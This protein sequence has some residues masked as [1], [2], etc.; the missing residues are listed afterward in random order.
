M[1]EALISKLQHFVQLLPHDKDVLNS[2][3]RERVRKFSPNEPIILEGD[4][5]TVINLVLSGWACRY[6]HLEDGRRQIV[7]FFLPGDLCD[8]NV[9]ILRQMDHSIASIGH[10]SVAEITPKAFDA[11]FENHYRITQGL[12]W[13]SLVAMAIQRE[14]TLNLGQRNAVERI[15]HLLCELFIRLRVAGVARDK[16][17][18]FPIRQIDLAD[19]TGMSPVHV[20]RVLH[21]LRDLQVISL[22]NRTLVVHD[23]KRLMEIGLFTANYLHLDRGAPALE[24]ESR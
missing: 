6:K 20:N 2:A 18:S 7:S 9:F 3:A 14:W 8:H 5:P 22:V 1:A 19:A 4:K 15:A 17:C 21:E 13:D 24:P 10:V 23:L 11:I 12:W 16:T